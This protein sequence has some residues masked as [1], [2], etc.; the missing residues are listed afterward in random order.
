MFATRI[1]DQHEND[2]L[3][4]VTCAKS[5]FILSALEF[6]YIALDFLNVNEDHKQLVIF[7]V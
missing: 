5:V 2:I 3:Y 4:S 7:P 1:R 6:I